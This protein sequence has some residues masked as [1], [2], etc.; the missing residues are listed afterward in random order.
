VCRP[1]PN[2][3]STQQN[4]NNLNR[5]AQG[6]VRRQQHGRSPNSKITIG[7]KAFRGH[8]AFV[9]HS[10]RSKESLFVVNHGLA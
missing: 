1:K 2:N 5:E 7:E 4:K 8:K 3:Q 6:F 10:E 9:R